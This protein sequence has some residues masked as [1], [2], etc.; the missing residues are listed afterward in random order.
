M[1]IFTHLRLV[2]LLGDD[3]VNWYQRNHDGQAREHRVSQLVVEEDEGDDDLEGAGP[4][5]VEVGEKVLEALRVHRHQV[6]YL[7]CCGLLAGR[8][9]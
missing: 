1:I 4:E 7:A 2:S 8:V 5:G 3:P 6:D 9:R